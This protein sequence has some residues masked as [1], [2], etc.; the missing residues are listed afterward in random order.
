MR[1]LLTLFSFVLISNSWSQINVQGKI[2]DSA[3]VKPI[4]GAI[5]IASKMK[6][7]LIVQFTRTNR[8]GEFQLSNLPIDTF[9]ITVGHPKFEDQ[10]LFIF[11]N[12]EEKKKIKYK[13]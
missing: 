11:G 10:Q 13:K 3:A 7:S 8:N 6:D 2:L 5:I 12:K 4:S 1:Y 9:K